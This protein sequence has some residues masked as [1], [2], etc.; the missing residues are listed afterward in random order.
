MPCRCAPEPNPDKLYFIETQSVRQGRWFLE[1]DR[2]SNSREH[3]IDLI[4][5][6]DVYPVKILEVCE[7]EGTVRDVTD[8]LID[9]AC[10]EEE[11][12]DRRAAAYDHAQDSR[13]NWT[14][15]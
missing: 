8:E 10:L 7:G 14:V 4:R 3:V 13:K 15:S 2:D 1:T 12:I 9:E 11:P 5:R 6:R